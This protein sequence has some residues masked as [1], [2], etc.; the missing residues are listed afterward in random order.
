VD[1]A[2]S[3]RVAAGVMDALGVPRAVDSAVPS[4]PGGPLGQAVCDHLAGDLPS[5]HPDRRWLVGRG[6]R[7]TGFDQLRI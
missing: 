1:K 2:E 3:I 7:I 4:A 6:S 5:S